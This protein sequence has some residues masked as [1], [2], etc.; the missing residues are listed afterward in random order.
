MSQYAVMEE[1]V[2]KICKSLTEDP[3]SWKFETCTFKKKGTNIEYWSTLDGPIVDVW[4]GSGRNQ[5]FSTEQG[6]RIR[7]AYIIARERQ[8]SVLQEQ[9]MASMK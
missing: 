9:V 1:T 8:A 6:E 4:L 7:K 2:N 3:H 5:V